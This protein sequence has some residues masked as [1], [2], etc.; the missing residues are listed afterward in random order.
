MAFVFKKHKMI[1]GNR[2]GPTANG[3]YYKPL[4][5]HG[6]VVK[7]NK[8]KGR[9]AK[10]AEHEDKSPWILDKSQQYD[11]FLEGVQGRFMD[12]ENMFSVLDN[13]NVIMGVEKE[14]IALFPVPPAG[15]VDW[16]GYPV[17]SKE[18][19]LTNEIM[20]MFFNAKV[21]DFTMYSRMQ[22]RDL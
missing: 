4:V 1:D 18:E 10:E 5:Y 20:D 17:S 9:K 11:V 6:K 22:R 12:N 16:H 21:I 15:T 13:C 7:S 2:Y 19:K 14:R 3:W 8:R